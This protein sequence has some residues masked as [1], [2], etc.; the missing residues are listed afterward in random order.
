MKKARRYGEPSFF[1]SG[2]ISWHKENVWIHR[3][4]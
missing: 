1:M 4:K 2:R 3:K